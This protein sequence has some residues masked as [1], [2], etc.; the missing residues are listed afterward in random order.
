M[1]GSGPLVVLASAFESKKLDPAHFLQRDV[2]TEEPEAVVNPER[3][4]S[5]V[6]G[7]DGMNEYVFVEKPHPA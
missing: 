4:Q 5:P 7:D 2:S 1:A 6:D 3:S